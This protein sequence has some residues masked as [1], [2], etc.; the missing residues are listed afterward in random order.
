MMYLGRKTS[1]PWKKEPIPSPPKK[2]QW[3]V[4]SSLAG[5]QTKLPM[6][7]KK[8]KTMTA[9]PATTAGVTTATIAIA[10]IVVLALPRQPS[11]ARPLAC[12][13]GR[14]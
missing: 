14:L 5:R 3:Q 4:P 9:S 2:I 11:A 1:P 12:T 6:T 7:P 8:P 10:M 13:G